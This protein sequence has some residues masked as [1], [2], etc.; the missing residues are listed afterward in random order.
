MKDK[1]NEKIYMNELAK[2]VHRG[3]CE[4]FFNLSHTQRRIHTYTQTG[5]K[6]RTNVGKHALS[7]EM[8]TRKFKN[9]ERLTILH[10]VF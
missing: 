4:I 9:V 10:C 8:S 5:Y 1:F 2:R 7:N 3:K 6:C